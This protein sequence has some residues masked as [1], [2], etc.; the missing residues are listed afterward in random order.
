MTR[1]PSPAFDAPAS[2]MPAFQP[3]AADTAFATLL[4]EAVRGT[5]TSDALEPLWQAWA[6]G[7]L[8]QDAPRTALVLYAPGQRRLLVSRAGAGRL[9]LER[10]LAR[11]REHPRCPALAA[12][13]GLCIQID[14]VTAPPVP[15]ELARVGMSLQ[16]S[17]HFEVGV[18]G[19]ELNAADGRRHLFLPGDAYVFSIMTMQGVRAHLR[20]SF[21]EETVEGAQCLRLRTDSYLIDAQGLHRLYRGI[22][23]VGPL[24]RDKLGHALQ[25]AVEHIQ[26]EQEAG[27]KYLYYYDAATDSRLDHE[28]PTRDPDTHPYYNILRHCGGALTCL[29]HGQLHRTDGSHAGVRRAIGYLATQ[30][31]SYDTPEGPAT[32]IYSERK[33]KLGGSGLALYLLA[34]YELATGDGQYRPFADR[35]A[36]HLARQ[37]T[38]SGEFIYYSIYLDQPIDEK[39]NANYF[40]F[41]YPGE[42]VC[43]LARYLHLVPEA[44]RAGYFERLHRALHYLIHVRPQERADQY[45]SVP[46]DAWLMMGI[47]ELWDYPEM[48]RE[49]YLAFVFGDA[50]QM[51]AQMYKVDTAPYPD[52]AGGF[53]YR[54]NDYPYSDGA[55]MEGM[56]GAYQ[57]A[58]KAQR[59]DVARELW[60]ALRLGA[61]ATLHLVNTEAAVYGAPNPLRSLGGIRFKY[62]RQWFRIDTI[63]HVASFYARL[64]AHWDDATAAGDAP[65]SSP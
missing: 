30:S 56:M 19:I 32:Y 36:R 52:Y 18:E 12:S 26:R 41:Y 65:C 22:P 27:G 48:R 16:G 3:N 46:S 54:F 6:A 39:G 5:R 21:G 47:K 4:Q 38:A 25:L 7:T 2:R 49:D 35:L 8:P 40:S 62:T 29:Y 60:P 15:M 53:Y 9:G 42:A 11:L 45:T 24:T 59:H 44:G 34:E 14:F 57:L 31:R 55:R 63:Q 43:G 51:I 37:I 61:W 50:R 33:A 13:A 10:T 17:R 28:H 23:L 20:A 64:L 1:P 58:L